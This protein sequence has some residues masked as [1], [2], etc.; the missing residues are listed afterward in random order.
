[1]YIYYVTYFCNSHANVHLFC[2]IQVEMI[3]DSCM[4]YIVMPCVW[5]RREKDEE[6]VNAHPPHA[7]LMNHN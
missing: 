4:D 5:I 7:N 1:M 6:K 2:A 3:G